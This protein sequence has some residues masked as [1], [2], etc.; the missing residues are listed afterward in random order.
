MFSGP[1]ALLAGFILLR[2]LISFGSFRAV[3]T[4]TPSS[5]AAVVILFRHCSFDDRRDALRRWK[6][7]DKGE[8]FILNIRPTDSD[9]LVIDRR[10]RAQEI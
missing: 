5:V 9:M 1:V 4:D 7:E 10:Q 8:A 2:N 3:F 6:W